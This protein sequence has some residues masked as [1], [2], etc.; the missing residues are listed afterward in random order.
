MVCGFHCQGACSLG[1]A[2][3]SR[4]NFSSHVQW[5]LGFR[6]ADLLF[7]GCRWRRVS[8][9]LCHLTRTASASLLPTW[10][11]CFCL[12]CVYSL[13]VFG[14]VCRCSAL[15]FMGIFVGLLD[16]PLLFFRVSVIVRGMS[17]V[18]SCKICVLY[19]Q[20]FFKSNPSD[21]EFKSLVPLVSICKPSG[22]FNNIS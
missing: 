2:C 3:G 18:Y 13:G 9:T 10:I 14:T 6:T 20:L 22:F 15:V 1:S 12:L 17:N 19:R 4:S 11:G 16:R 21:L 5:F 7:G 8:H